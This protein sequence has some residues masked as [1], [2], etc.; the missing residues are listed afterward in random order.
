MTL[1]VKNA[2]TMKSVRAN[3]AQRVLRQSPAEG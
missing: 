3:R 2:T 1:F